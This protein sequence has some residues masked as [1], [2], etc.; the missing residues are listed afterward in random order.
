MV[1]VDLWMTSRRLVVTCKKK[2]EIDECQTTLSIVG[3]PHHSNGAAVLFN[4]MYPHHFPS[5]GPTIQM[6]DSFRSK[7]PEVFDVQEELT[8]KL[9]PGEDHH[10]SEL[11]VMM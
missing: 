11:T 9:L 5:N 1:G 2:R 10:P 7:H 4:G 6:S 8:A 3:S